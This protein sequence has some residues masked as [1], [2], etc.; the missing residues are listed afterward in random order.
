M[1][2]S[3]A[4]WN[5]TTFGFTLEERENEVYLR[6]S[7]TG[8]VNNNDELKHSSFCWAMLLNGLKKYVEK[9]VIIPFEERE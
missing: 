3:D 4:D 2:N 6:F 1:T 5:P 8:W 7:H 9:G